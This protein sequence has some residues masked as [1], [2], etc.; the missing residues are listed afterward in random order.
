MLHPFP[1]LKSQSCKNAVSKMLSSACKSKLHDWMAVFSCP[2]LCEA[3]DVERIRVRIRQSSK[4]GVGTWDSDPADPVDSKAHSDP[5]AACRCQEQVA[6][7]LETQE[8]A[9]PR[10]V[11]LST[12]SWKHKVNQRPGCTSTFEPFNILFTPLTLPPAELPQPQGKM[13]AVF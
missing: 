7:A 6:V 13:L 11:Q 5:P 1:D 12:E 4:C 10:S 2:V 3:D 9:K 8:G